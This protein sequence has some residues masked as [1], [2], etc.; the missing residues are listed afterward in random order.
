M[1]EVQAIEVRPKKV[2]LAGR[3]KGVEVSGRKKSC[4]KMN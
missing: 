4:G 1:T 2:V 3:N